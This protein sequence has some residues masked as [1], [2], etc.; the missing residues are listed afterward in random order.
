MKNKNMAIYI[1]IALLLIA[2]LL[3]YVFAPKPKNTP[4]APQPQAASVVAAPEPATVP[5]PPE[6]THETPPDTTTPE[7]QATPAA[8]SQP[9]SY[10]VVRGDCLWRIAARSDVYGNPDEWPLIYKA[11]SD[12]IKDADLIY[13]GQV[14]VINHHPSA[15]AV[16]AAIQHAK[17]R[18]PWTLGKVEA[19]DKA[20]LAQ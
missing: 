13:P 15:A 9:A 4:A 16:A 6:P 2:L 1:V 8:P 14:L 17:T 3:W 5:P 19:S 20:Y 11:N 18:G 12:R 10:T 7:Q